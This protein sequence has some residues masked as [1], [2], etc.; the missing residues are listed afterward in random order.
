MLNAL[1]SSLFALTGSSSGGSSSPIRRDSAASYPDTSREN[2]LDDDEGGYGRPRRS[3]GAAGVAGVPSP[4]GTPTAASIGTS[5]PRVKH[6]MTRLRSMMRKLNPEV[7]DTLSYPAASKQIAELQKLL[8][9]Y[10]IPKDVLDAYALHD[11][12]DSFS[13]P[14]MGE[15]GEN[16]GNTGFVYGLWWMSI[17]EII[18][19]YTFW[20]RLDVSNPPSPSAPKKRNDVKGKGKQQHQQHTARVPSQDAFLFGSE[21]DPRTVRATMRSCPEG[22]V[23]EEYSH[24]SWL[25]LLKD[26]YGNYIGIDLDPP[27]LSEDEKLQLSSSPAPPI[28]PARGQVIA[29]GREIDT[30]TVLWNGWGDSDAYD[31]LGGGGWARFLASFADDL[32]ATSALHKQSRY[33]YDG[34]YAGRTGSDDDDDDAYRHASGGRQEQGGSHRP[35]T[36]LEWLDSSPIYS[37][38]GTIEALVERSRRIWS[39]VGMPM[40]VSTPAQETIPLM[41]GDAP[42]PSPFEQNSQAGIDRS[43]KP[44]PLTFTMP[45]TGSA[46]AHVAASSEDQPISPKGTA[47]P[48]ETERS[49]SNPPTSA[50]GATAANV[51]STT[52]Q[53]ALMQGTL[54]PS[55]SDTSF[56]SNTSDG[57]DTAS[58]IALVQPQEHDMK[59]PMSPEPS[60]VLSPPSPK[61]NAEQFGPFPSMSSPII[62]APL[63]SEVA[64]GASNPTTPTTA[65]PATT[66][67]S[68]RKSTMSPISPGPLSAASLQSPARVSPGQQAR[69]AERQQYQ[70]RRFSDDSQRRASG[71]SS[72]ASNRT[73]RGPPPPAMPLGLP[74]LEFGNGIWEHEDTSE[75]DVTTYGYEKNSFEVVIDGHA[76]H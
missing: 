2:D 67:T 52:S 35:G 4:T 42:A 44:P 71:S 23:R 47:H 38:L 13:V 56:P 63:N 75:G 49:M 50:S 76:R 70:D 12:Q 19:E 1:K 28:L 37:G 10:V 57:P 3:A 55:P 68:P 7:L 34:S 6:T 69:Y 60:L 74:T 24:P 21:M 25:P 51:G 48:L 72:A 40:P 5:V 15:N 17:E 61:D 58:N 64:T 16:E 59:P 46:A 29:F 22:F 62:D 14:R 45:G 18:E 27:T 30:K 33:N 43:R 20:R 66:S 53:T 11:G 32:S 31:N 65:H 9:D 41:N 39:S 54:V 8:K 73:R 36:G 26:G